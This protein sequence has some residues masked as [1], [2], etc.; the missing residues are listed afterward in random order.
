VKRTLPRDRTLLERG[1][2]GLL[3]CFCLAVVLFDVLPLGRLALAAL[4]PK[5]VLAPHEALQAIAGRAAVRATVATLETAFGSA[6]L[7]LALGT[8]TGLLVSLT[9]VRWRRGFSFLFVLSMMVAPQVMALAFLTLAGPSS[10]ILHTLGWSPAPGSGNPLLG[11]GGIVLVLGLHHAP[12]VF[13]LVVAGLKRIPHALVEAAQVDGNPPLRIV[14]GILLPLLRPHLASAALLAFVAGAGN[15]GIAAVLGLPVNYVT[16]PTLIYRRLVS[17][18]PAVI[19]DAAA[20]GLLVAVVAGAGVVASRLALRGDPL[21]LEDGRPVEPFWRLGRAKPAAEG[22]LLFLIAVVFAVPMAGLVTAALVP[23]YGVPLTAATATLD[24][25][26]EV[27]MRQEATVRAFGNSFLFAGGS[28]ALLA[29]LAV[30]LAYAVER[31]AGP[32]TRLGVALMEVPYV[33]PGIV[34]AIACIL[35]FLKPLPIL[36]FSIYAT[37]WIIVFAYLARFLP[38]ALKPAL[39]AMAQ[40]DPAQEEAAALDGADLP[41]RLVSIV[42]PALVPAAA[43]GGLLAFLL[44]FGE[45]TVSALLWSA[46]TETVGVVLFSLEEAGLASQA[47]AVAVVTVA[48]VTAAMALLDLMAARLPAGALPWRP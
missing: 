42:A 37:S 47:A 30:P 6:L 45:L 5:G 12:L 35:V 40:L 17:F 28:A 34:L 26:V 39:A 36:G 10:P 38:V 44:A 9:D 18:G 41:R 14:A 33:L 3:A 21:L 48:V 46:G 29:V 16:L 20:L 8:A 25:F 22:A 1:G 13:I 27:L 19:G 11:R 7:A 43:A 4:A 32:A 2:F 24:N 15:F 23:T 31:R